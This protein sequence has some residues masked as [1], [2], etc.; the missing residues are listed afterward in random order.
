MECVQEEER[1]PISDAAPSMRA[2]NAAPMRAVVRVAR[3]RAPSERNRWM[4]WFLSPVVFL[5]AAGATF[6]VSYLRTG[7][8]TASTPRINPL[9]DPRSATLK[10]RVNS[11]GP[12][13]RLS[14]NRFSPVVQAAK[15]GVLEIDDGGRH[16]EITLDRKEIA[17]GSVLYR[18]ASGDVSFL[19]DLRD[20]GGSDFAQVLRV[21]D[22]SAPEPALEA[23]IAAKPSVPAAV[24]MSSKSRDWDAV[25][26]QHPS[27]TVAIVEDPLPAEDRAA[28]RGSASGNAAADAGRKPVASAKIAAVIPPPPNLPAVWQAGPA[29]VEKTPLAALTEPQIQATA[30]NAAPV[31]IPIANPRPNLAVGTPALAPSREAQ[32]SGYVPPRPLKWVQPDMRFL[33]ASYPGAPVD[34]RVKVRI[35]E[36]GHVTAAHALLDGSTRDQK[37]LAVAADAVRQWIFEPAKNNGTNVPSEE[38]IVIRLGSKRQ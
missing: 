7:P 4:T 24:V 34:I 5:L 30:P 25:K 1:E 11:Q 38:T 35:D 8:V 2:A 21:L 17:N 22:A 32:L 27:T 13:L 12:G 6:L 3:L 19:L 14:W 10:M 15:S 33:G 31:K 37:L 20:T 28:K 36:R 23:V 26:Y 9:S 29:A 18:P 16:H